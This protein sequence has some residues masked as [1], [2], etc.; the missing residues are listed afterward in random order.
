MTAL[1]YVRNLGGGGVVADRGHRS[2]A[3]P[4]PTGFVAW[5]SGPSGALRSSGAWCAVM[6]SPVF[7]L[8]A[9]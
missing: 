1:N 5:P 8:Y 7:A 2:Q 6:A 9:V 4:P 3:P